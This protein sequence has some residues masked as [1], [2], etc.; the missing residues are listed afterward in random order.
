MSTSGGT[1][2]SASESLGL[3][4]HELV[5]G[6]DGVSLELEFQLGGDEQRPDLQQLLETVVRESAKQLD[7]DRQQDQQKR[8]EEQEKIL[9]ALLQ[10]V[11]DSPIR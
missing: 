4:L 5:I 6:G 10:L 7:N 8:G 3:L 11:P 2:S 1:N 9:Q